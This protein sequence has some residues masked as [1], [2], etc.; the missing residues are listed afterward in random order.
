ML[1]DIQ[2]PD[3]PKQLV[4]LSAKVQLV[5]VYDNATTEQFSEDREHFLMKIRELDPEVKIEEHPIGKYLVHY[6]E[7]FLSYL[8]NCSTIKP[9]RTIKT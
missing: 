5:L 3:C 2:A 7:E 6:I 4:H 9:R 8:Y 1:K